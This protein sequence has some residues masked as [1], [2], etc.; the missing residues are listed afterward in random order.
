MPFIPESAR[1]LLSRLQDTNS[2]RYPG[3]VVTRLVRDRLDERLPHVAVEQDVDSGRHVVGQFEKL[4][5]G[6]HWHQ[7]DTRALLPGVFLTAAGEI[8]CSGGDTPIPR[9]SFSQTLKGGP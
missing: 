7:D 8:S 2:V 9:G 5:S 1:G 3:D 6:R 4:L